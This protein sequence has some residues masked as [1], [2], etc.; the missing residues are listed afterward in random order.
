MGFVEDGP[1]S[2]LIA[3]R[4]IQ[5]F[6]K[7]PRHPKKGPSVTSVGFGATRASQERFYEELQTVGH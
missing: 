7:K 3:E 5:Q 2:E 1:Q 6:M 4:D